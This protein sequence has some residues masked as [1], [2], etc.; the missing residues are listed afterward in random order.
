MSSFFNI[1]Y[2]N[3]MK[4]ANISS[5]DSFIDSL[6]SIN[7]TFFWINIIMYIIII[8]LIIYLYIAPKDYDIVDFNT[9][10]S[11]TGNSDFPNFNI[12]NT[13]TNN[14]NNNNYP[15]YNMDNNNNPNYANAGYNS[16]DY[17]KSNY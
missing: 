12:N 5:I 16:Y 10:N 1:N 2:L 4:E 6:I 3:K 13:S 9:K 11:Q 7:R 15:Y 14:N 8:L 17:N